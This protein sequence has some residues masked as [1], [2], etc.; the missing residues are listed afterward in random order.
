[1]G[2][3]ELAEVKLKELLEPDARERQEQS[4]AVPGE[5]IGSK[6]GETLPSPSDKGQS[7]DK[8]AAAVGVS[9]KLVDAAA[10]LMATGSAELVA[11]VTSAR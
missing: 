3:E 7:R 5:K 10:K 11:A 1:M 8:A 9:G 2:E 4:R 6:V